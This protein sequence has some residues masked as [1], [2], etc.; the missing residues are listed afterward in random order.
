MNRPDRVHRARA[1]LDF[2]SYNFGLRRR[3]TDTK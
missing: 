3:R 2:I 1:F